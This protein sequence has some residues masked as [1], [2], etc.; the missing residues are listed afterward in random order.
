M[1]CAGGKARLVPELLARAP[2]TFGAYHEPFVGGGA[3]FFAL[4]PRRAFLSDAN[5]DL[6]AAYE[7]VRDRPKALAER[8]ETLAETHAADPKST[9]YQIRSERPRSGLHRAARLIYL[10]KT[11]FNGLWRVNSKGEF[12]VPIGDYKRP[13]LFDAFNL[14]ACS[15][16]LNVA[17]LNAEDFRRVADRAIAGDLVYFD[18]PYVP[19]SETSSFASYA[20]GGFGPQDQADLR[21]LALV[22]KRR[23]VHVLLS[24]SGC[25]EVER[26]YSKDFQIHKVKARRSINSKKAGRGAVVEYVI[27]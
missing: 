23:G 12:N 27:S 19:L 20:A 9:Y 2:K 14:G 11:C 13:T 10:N 26:L 1:K 3:L 18:P 16:A 17:T 24:N 5:P 25:E 6:I 7:A 21:D 22:L 4:R 8:L 15:T